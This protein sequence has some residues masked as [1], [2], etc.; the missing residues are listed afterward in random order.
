[1]LVRDLASMRTVDITSTLGV[2]LALT[3]ACSTPYRADYPG[4]TLYYDKSGVPLCAGCRERLYEDL[5]ERGGVD[6]ATITDVI[7]EEEPW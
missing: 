6:F 5:G 3:F 2:S 7:I 1:M 4:H